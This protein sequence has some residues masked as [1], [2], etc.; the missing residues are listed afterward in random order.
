MGPV[1]LAGGEAAL[2]GIERGAIV[3]RTQMA[4][5]FVERALADH[6]RIVGGQRGGILRCPGI[7]GLGEQCPGIAL[8]HRIIRLGAG[9]R[10]RVRRALAVTGLQARLREPDLDVGV[11]LILQWRE[12]PQRGVGMLGGIG[13]VRP[14][15]A[16][17][18][19]FLRGPVRALQRPGEILL[20]DLWLLGALRQEAVLRV[21]PWLVRKARQHGIGLGARCLQLAFAGQHIEQQQVELEV[22]GL[23]PQRRARR[24]LGRIK[25]VG[26]DG[27]V[28]AIGMAIGIGRQRLHRRRLGQRAVAERPDRHRDRPAQPRRQGAEDVSSGGHATPPA[29]LGLECGDSAQGRLSGAGAASATTGAGPPAPWTALASAST[30]SVAE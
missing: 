7:R 30:A 22:V 26:G 6:A 11:G 29:T 10:G 5:R 24:L 20:R 3:V 21:D 19:L 28:S 17:V 27:L 25:L 8:A 18:A 9:Q 12:S 14:R 13:A 1:A 16:Q 4:V 15:Q 23:H 2:E